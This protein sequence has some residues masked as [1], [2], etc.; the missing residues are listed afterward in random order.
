MARCLLPGEAGVSAGSSRDLEVGR[1][2]LAGEEITLPAA[3]WPWPAARIIRWIGLFV[4]PQFLLLQMAMKAWPSED[5]AWALPRGQWCGTGGQGLAHGDL[6]SSSGFL[7][8]RSGK[9]RTGPFL[10]YSWAPLGK[11]YM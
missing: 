1:S 9:G 11:D 4:S 8:M 5:L 7:G 6:R 2:P 10:G 3:G